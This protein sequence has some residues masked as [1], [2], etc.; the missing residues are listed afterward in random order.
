MANRSAFIL[1]FFSNSCNRTP[2]RAVGPDEGG[3]HPRP[4]TQ[5][6]TTK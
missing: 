6:R 5:E 4:G 3:N 1:G 2:I